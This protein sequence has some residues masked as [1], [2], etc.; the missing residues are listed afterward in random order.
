VKPIDPPGPRFRFE[1]YV[2]DDASNGALAIANLTAFCDAVLPGRHDIEIVDVLKQPQRAVEQ[3]IVMTPTLLK[4]AP[5]PVQKIVGTL[6]QADALQAA[7][8]L[9]AGSRGAALGQG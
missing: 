5:L 1:L 3:G 2:A 4:L 6:G 7:L 8:G 9:D